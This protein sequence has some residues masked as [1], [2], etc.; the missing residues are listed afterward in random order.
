[1]NIKDVLGIKKQFIIG[2][3]HCL[4]LPGTPGYKG[5]CRKILDQAVSDAVTLEKAGVDAVIVENMGDSPF[6]EKLSSE[7]FAGL[8]AATSCVKKAVKIPVG[9]DAAFCD[10]KASLIIAKVTGC[11]FIRVAVFVDTVLFTD[12]IIYPSAHDCMVYRKQIDGENIMILADVQVKH[13]RMVFQGISVEDSAKDAVACGADAII[14]TGTGT[15]VETPITLIKSIKQTVKVPVIAGSG[16]TKENIYDQMQI[17]DGVIVGSS[18]KEG[19]K[20][21]NPISYSLA[22]DLVS[23]IKK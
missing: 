6:S 18:L 12:G 1:M 22:H 21:E 23:T 17:A 3:V 5:D 16:V 10:S 15:G 11:E 20:L 4:P 13:T 9:V 7:Q 8:C 19:G 14:V 2:M